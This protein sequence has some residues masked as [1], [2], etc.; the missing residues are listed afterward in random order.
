MSLPHGRIERDG[1][2]L[3]C[4]IGEQRLQAPDANGSAAALAAYGGADVAVGVRPEHLGDPGKSLHDRRRLGRRVRVRRAARG[5]RLV[6]IELASKPVTIDD[7]LE[8]AQGRCENGDGHPAR[9][10][11]YH[12]LVT[13]RFATALIPAG[14]PAESVSGAHR[15]P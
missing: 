7:V 1:D 3:H 5:G 4:R 10:A 12:A 15:G 8:P 11:S 6:Q 9:S 13:A 2:A 14:M